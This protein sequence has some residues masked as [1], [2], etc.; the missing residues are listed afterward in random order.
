MSDNRRLEILR[1]SVPIQGVVSYRFLQNGAPSW[2][3][4]VRATLPTIEYF[5]AASADGGVA[6]A[7]PSRTATISLTKQRYHRVD[8]DTLE[9]TTTLTDPKVYTKPWVSEKKTFRLV[10]LVQLMSLR[11]S[12][13]FRS[14]RNLGLSSPSIRMLRIVSIVFVSASIWSSLSLARFRRARAIGAFLSA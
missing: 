3:T 9:L 11:R 5:S 4:S 10:Q 6:L 8:R 14:R 13:V 7:N 1:S 2:E 12:V